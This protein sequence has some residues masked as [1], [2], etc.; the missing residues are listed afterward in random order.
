MVL[1]GRKIS[2]VRILPRKEDCMKHLTE[3]QKAV[4]KKN[5]YHDIGGS[6]I[7]LYKDFTEKGVAKYI[8]DNFGA[9]VWLIRTW[10]F[11]GKKYKGLWKVK[12]QNLIKIQIYELEDGGYDFNVIDKSN[13]SRY[14]AWKDKIDY[15]RSLGMAD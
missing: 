10:V 11:K 5:A 7:L 15:D 14:N 2:I 4:F 6:Y 9:G 3:K 12:W 13:I 1:Y 8:H